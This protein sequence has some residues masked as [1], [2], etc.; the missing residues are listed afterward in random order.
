[1]R[2]HVVE[3]RHKDERFYELC[4][5]YQRTIGPLPHDVAS[6]YELF[7][8]KDPSRCIISIV[9][10]SRALITNTKGEAFP[11]LSFHSPQTSISMEVKHCKV[12]SS[13]LCRIAGI[14]EQGRGRPNLCS[15]R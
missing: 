9:G 6:V 1:M 3:G 8:G 11:D 13:R 14:W 4:P 15:K 7:G 12:L 10:P 2:V 5:L